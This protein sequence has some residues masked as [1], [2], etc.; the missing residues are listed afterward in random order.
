[1]VLRAKGAR[2]TRVAVFNLKSG[3]W[4]PLDLDRPVNGGVSPM[5]LGPDA[6]AYEVGEVLYVFNAKTDAWDRLDLRAI[7]E[8]KPEPRAIKAR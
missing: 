2:I 6:L 8:D 5:S 1:M 7:A 3:K 4:S